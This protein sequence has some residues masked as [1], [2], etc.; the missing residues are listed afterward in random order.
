MKISFFKRASA[1]AG[2]VWPRRLLAVCA[3][4]VLTVVSATLTTGMA[5]AAPTT[6]SAQSATFRG[7][8]MGTSVS[9]A[10]AAANRDAL[11]KAQASGYPSTSCSLQSSE[12]HFLG[13]GWYSADVVFLCQKQ[14]PNPGPTPVPG[15]VSNTELKAGHTGMCAAVGDNSNSPGMWFIQ[16]TC[17]GKANKKFDLV[18]TGSPSQ[19]SLKVK[20]TGLCMAPEGP[21]NHARIVQRQCQSTPEFR[22]TLA[23]QSDGRFTMA[24]GQSNLCLGVAWGTT[25]SGQPLDQ[26]SCGAQA[27][28]AWAIPGL[29]SPGGGGTGGGGGRGGGVSTVPA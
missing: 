24:N 3:A 17:D 19:Y 21:G 5:S 8:A 16:F 11:G 14:V 7:S 10:Y 9:E 4:V 2:R 6:A 25:N 26:A 12:Y 18:P 27:G 22:W 29:G 15:T 23:S 1:G 28:Q 13:I 20:S